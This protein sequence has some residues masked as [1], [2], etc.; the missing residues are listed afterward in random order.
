[1]REEAEAVFRDERDKFLGF[2]RKNTGYSSSIDAEDVLQDVALGIFSAPSL[3]KPVENFLAYVYASIK[4][5]IID[6]YR[7]SSRK[8][9][10]ISLDEFEYLSEE[11]D[12]PDSDTDEILQRVESAY[13]L[14]EALDEL[15]AEQREI[16]IATEM[17]DGNLS[18]IAREKGIPIGTL[19]AR[20]HR[21][22]KKLRSLL[23]DLYENMNE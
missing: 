11:I 5:R 21:A 20:K 16:W 14:F 4:N 17:E 15:N 12:D 2:I 6:I 22:T 3:E 13:R 7:S 18:E 10:Q 23:T 8:K 1:V 9:A 19:L